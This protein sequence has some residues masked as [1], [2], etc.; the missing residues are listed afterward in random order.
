VEANEGLERSVLH[1][2]FFKFW[3]KNGEVGHYKITE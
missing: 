1:D 2:P 3:W